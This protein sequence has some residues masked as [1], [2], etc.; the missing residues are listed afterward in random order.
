MNYKSAVLSK[1]L[2]GLCIVFLAMTSWSDGLPGEYLL[3]QR[4]RDIHSSYSPLTNAAFLIEED[5][6][7]VR[8]A[9]APVLQR[10][11]TLW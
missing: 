1:K 5:Y 6:F 11:F 4:W 8:G 7:S 3:T 9:V 10:S 2:T